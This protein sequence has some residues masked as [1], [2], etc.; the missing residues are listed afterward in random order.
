M[1]ATHQVITLARRSVAAFVYAT[2]TAFAEQQ[3][4]LD[5][6][7]SIMLCRKIG[8]FVHLL[9]WAAAVLSAI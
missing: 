2:R 3:V 7:R 6:D 1:S 4:P 9:Q 5:G 8:A